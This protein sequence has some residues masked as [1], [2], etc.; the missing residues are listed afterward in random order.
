MNPG[1]IFTNT[2]KKIA[3]ITFGHPASN[4]FPTELLQR[5]IDTIN[6][7][8]EDK[9]INLI[10]LKSEGEKSFCA[11][12]FFDELLTIDNIAQGTA[13]FGGFADLMN[14]MRKSSK[15]IMARI[16]GKAVGGGVGI[17]AAADYCYATESADIKLSELSIGLGPFVIAPAVE[18]KMGKSGLT[19]LTLGAHEWKT[20]YWAKEKGLYAKVFEN[21]REM[22]DEIELFSS[23]ISGYS[24]ESLAALKTVLWKGTEDWDTLLPKYAAIN[25]KLVLSDFTKNA[26]QKFK[27]KL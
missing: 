19:E 15:I 23:K 1:T 24:T 21:I 2:N 11:G 17:A 3:T 10:I 12:A 8:S 9:E 27:N 16:Q 7:V 26:L 13:F 18:R 4:A 22:D 5:L 20:A 6:R 14:S 25:G